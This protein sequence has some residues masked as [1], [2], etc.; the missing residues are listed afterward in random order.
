MGSPGQATIGAQTGDVEPFSI[1][2]RGDPR[3][4]TSILCAF[5]IAEKLRKMGMDTKK[6]ALSFVGKSR[7]DGIGLESCGVA[8]D[9]LP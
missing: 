2:C 7:L 4:H 3:G 6:P 8:R 1:Y 9:F 5:I